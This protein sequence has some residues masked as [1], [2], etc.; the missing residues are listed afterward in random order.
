MFYE[1]W[2]Q[3]GRRCAGCDAPVRGGQEVGV[4]FML[5]SSRS[6]GGG[7]YSRVTHRKGA[8]GCRASVAGSGW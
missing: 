5:L 3:A 8:R 4:F 7:R 1:Q 6:H 2:E